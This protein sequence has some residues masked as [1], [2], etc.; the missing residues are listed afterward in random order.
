MI[1]LLK[2]KNLKDV[3][4]LLFVVL[5]VTDLLNCTVLGTF[6]TLISFGAIKLTS[7]V[8]RSFSSFRVISMIYN[9]VVSTQSVSKI[10]TKILLRTLLPQDMLSM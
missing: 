2:N 1:F 9:V 6:Q 7:F 8:D 4:T 3:P 10:L 5:C